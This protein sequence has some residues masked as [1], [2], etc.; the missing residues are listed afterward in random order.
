VDP[1]LVNLQ[2]QQCFSSVVIPVGYR[3][4]LLG[5]AAMYKTFG[6]EISTLEIARCLCGFPVSRFG[7][8]VNHLC[9][10]LFSLWM[11]A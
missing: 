9:S 6:G 2:Q 7:N 4:D 1:G 3:G 8:A 10:P 11:L 5:G